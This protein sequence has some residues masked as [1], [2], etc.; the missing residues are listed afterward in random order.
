MDNL[1]TQYSVTRVIL[2]L[3]LLYHFA[4]IIFYADELLGS[5]MPY[6]PELGP[7]YNTIFFLNVFN[8]IDA[9]LVISI[10]FVPIICFTVGM[11]PRIN[12]II[13]WLIWASAVNRNVLIS[14]PGIP[15]IGWVLLFFA[16][17]NNDNVHRKNMY[18][19]AW[20]MMALGYTMSGLHKLDCPSWLDGTALTHVLNSPLAR[21]NF[22]RD[23]VLSMPNIIL[24]LATWFSLFL[25]IS[26]LPLGVFYYT[27]I[28]YWFTYLFF[29]IGIIMT[30]NFADLTFG[31]FMIHILTFDIEWI[32][33]IRIQ[34][35]TNK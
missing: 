16:C 13:T 25:E 34:F 15:Y 14:N 22:V 28:V 21:D 29:H 31:V 12:A 7:T 20:F 26:F 30:I 8:W 4:E 19:L 6:N 5:S 1:S 17:L 23:F 3:Y 35:A 10:A 24:K 27:R 2:G 32:N 9:K 18:W 11:Y 33:F